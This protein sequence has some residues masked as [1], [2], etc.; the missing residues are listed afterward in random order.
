[1]VGKAL[2]GSDSETYYVTENSSEDRPGALKTSS[3][4]QPRHKFEA[5][6]DHI[7]NDQGITR[8]EAMSQARMNFPDVYRSYQGH[9]SNSDTNKR[10]PQTFENYVQAEMRK[11]VTREVAGQRIA[12]AHGFN[13]FNNDA[14]AINKRAWDLGAEFS[15][16]AEDVYG[17]SVLSRTEA[18]RATRLA[19]PSLYRKMQRA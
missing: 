17:N 14:G 19:N 12:Q 8:S 2:D 18:L 3:H 15:K 7:R 1:V 11:G 6:V 10:A 4:S 9:T 16:R 5:L 13:A